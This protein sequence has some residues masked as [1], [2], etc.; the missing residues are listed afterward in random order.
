[1]V[2]AGR[3]IDVKAGRVLEDQGIV[4]EGERI[5]AVGPYAQVR[6]QAP[7]SALSI[8]LSKATVLPG[9]ID[10]HTHVLLQGDVTQADYDEQILKE[11]IP[12]RTLRA[13][14]A[15]RTAVNNGFTAIRDLETQGAI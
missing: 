10:G 7:S 12:F 2:R 6:G 8:D 9:L 3:L 14:V 4:V 15:A 13:S 1:L 5:K 11:S